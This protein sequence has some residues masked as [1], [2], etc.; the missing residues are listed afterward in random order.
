MLVLRR[1]RGSW[2]E[3]THA[4][5]GDVIRIKIHLVIPS[6]GRVDLAFEDDARHFQ[7]DREE[8]KPIPSPSDYDPGFKTDSAPPT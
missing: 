6:T 5:S 2:V 1:K 4:A 7:I 8:R 3:I